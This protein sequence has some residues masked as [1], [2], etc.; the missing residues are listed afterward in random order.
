MPF[1]LSAYAPD[2]VYPEGSTYWGYG[3]M[4]TVFTDAMFESAFGTDFGL[5]KVPG[6]MESADFRVLSIGPSGK[7]YNFSDCGDHR[8]ENGDVT[9][10]WFAAR[11]GNKT[12]FEKDRFLAPPA[13]MGKLNRNAGAALVWISQFNEERRE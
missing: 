12:Y 4:F 3:T 7:Y 8:D 5:A 11:T 9:L 1:G 13:S 10:A 6:F 2:G